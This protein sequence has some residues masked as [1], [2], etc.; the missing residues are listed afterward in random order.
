MS[1]YHTSRNGAACVGGGRGNNTVFSAEIYKS[2][3][4]RS[5]RRKVLIVQRQH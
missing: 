1:E 2:G 4:V 3:Y 5:K